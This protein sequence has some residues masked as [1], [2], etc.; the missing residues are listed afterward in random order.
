SDF[1]RAKSTDL[2]LLWFFLGGIR[3]DDPALFHFLLFERLHWH[4]IAERFYVNCCHKVLLSLLLFFWFKPATVDPST[5]VDKL[6]LFLLVFVHYFELCIDDVAAVAL[7]CALFCCA[8]AWLRFRPG[9]RTWTRTG[10]R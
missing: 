6:S 8:A 1:A 2:S 9:L 10:L 7:T 5:A 4:S 3:D